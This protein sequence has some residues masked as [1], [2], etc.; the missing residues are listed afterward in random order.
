MYGKICNFLHYFDLSYLSEV[1]FVDSVAVDNNDGTSALCPSQTLLD[2]AGHCW[3]LLDTA[4]HCWTQLDTAGHCETLLDSA[5]HCWRLLDTA[6]DCWTLL[7]TAGHCCILL[8]TAGHCWTQ[9]D[10]AG[11]CWTLLDTAGHCCI[12]LDTAGL[13]NM[14]YII[15]CMCYMCYMCILYTHITS[16]SGCHYMIA[17]TCRILHCLQTLVLCIFTT[18]QRIK[19]CRSGY[20]MAMLFF[21]RWYIQ[22]NYTSNK[23]HRLKIS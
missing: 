16:I 3:T 2:T 8:D 13:Y 11:H 1:R 19:I 12:L 5:G 4:G 20:G 6:G 14:W 21:I 7:H 22:L 10:T 23:T 9:L 17:S 18:F 15:C